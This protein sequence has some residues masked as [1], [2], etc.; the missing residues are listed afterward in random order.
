MN[1]RT[2]LC[3]FGKVAVVDP[4]TVAHYVSLFL[5]WSLFVCL[6]FFLDSYSKT[7]ISLLL[8]FV[9]IFHDGG[10]FASPASGE[11]GSVLAVVTGVV[12]SSPL[13]ESVSMTKFELV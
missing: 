1:E 7:T 3:F 2:A 6:S 8:F 13:S 11:S 5:L 12:C 4:N 9:F 10:G